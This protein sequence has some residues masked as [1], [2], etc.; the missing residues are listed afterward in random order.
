MVRMGHAILL[1]DDHAGVRSAVR[2]DLE[3]LGYR[4]CAEADDADSA[5]AAAVRERP[6]LC[7]LDLR[8][9]GDGVAA[10]RAIH[11]LLPEAYIVMLTVSSDEADIR[12]SVDAGVVGYLLK[13]TPAERLADALETV[14]A[15][16]RALPSQ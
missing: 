14:L 3:D 9:P 13:D 6:D 2:A 16:G 5:V 11:E 1:A 15:G 8:M 12:R 10:A 7:L 4:V